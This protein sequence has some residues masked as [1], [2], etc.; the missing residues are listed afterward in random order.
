[1]PTMDAPLAIAQELTA[2]ERVEHLLTVV[3]CSLTGQPAHVVCPWRRAG[4]DSFFKAV[5]RG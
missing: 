1:M 4:I 5:G 3:A 2:V